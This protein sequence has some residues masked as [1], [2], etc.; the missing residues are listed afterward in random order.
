MSSTV[1]TS[2]VPVRSGAA[3]PAHPLPSAYTLVL[4][5]ALVGVT[6]FGLLADD[7]YR[8]SPGVRATF[9]AVMQGQDLLTLLSVPVLIWVARQAHH[10]SLRGHLV[11]L[12]LLLYY[13]YTYLVY[14]LSPFNDVF[15]AYTLIIAMSGYGFLNGLLRL[16]MRAV[17]PVMT[18]VPRRSLAVFLLTVAGIFL[19]LWL[20]MIVPAIPG[21]LPGGRVTYDIASVVHVLDLSVVLPLIVGTGWLLLRKHPAGPVLGVV[22][23]CKIVTLGL[24][25]TSMNLVFLDGPDAGELTLWLVITAVALPWLAVCLRRMTRPTEPWIRH[26][27]WC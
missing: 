24:A 26:T 20:S 7:A 23:L 12:G 10:G 4:S 18:A 14:A 11:W 6:L 13:A 22:L 15:L 8:V 19:G 25:L 16:D 9:P 5:A 1:R 21:G 2:G 27:L 3:P 17:A